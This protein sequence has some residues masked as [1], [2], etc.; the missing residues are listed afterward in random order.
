MH[1]L[2]DTHTFL[3]VLTERT[4]L[5][6]QVIEIIEDASQEVF[7]SAV[8]LWEIAI[9]LRSGRLEIGGRS[10]T[11]VLDEARNMNLHVISLDPVE[12][13]RHGS[14]N[15]DTH[16]DPFD[17]ILIWQ[18][19]ERKLTLISSDRAFQKFVP[20]GLELLWE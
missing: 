10:A 5:P 15:E 19:I 1:Y 7:L 6:A 3:W 13:A 16:F 12:A 14:L 20:D 2:L 18:A 8:S 17:R 4:K 11:D 9:K